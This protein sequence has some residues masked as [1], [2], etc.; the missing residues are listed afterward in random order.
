M[1][2]ALTDAYM[3][4]C[5]KRIVDGVEN[6][7]IK[8]IQSQKIYIKE[9][10]G[11]LRYSMKNIT[12]RDDDIKHIVIAGSQRDFLLYI[13]EVGIS[14]SSALFA[15]DKRVVSSMALSNFKIHITVDAK[16]SKNNAIDYIKNVL[17]GSSG[18]LNLDI[19][20]QHTT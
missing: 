8:D 1:N 20:Q 7:T 11:K 19:V 13:E 15:V 6:G 18:V 4:D 10:E 2:K 17:A 3:E 12:E 16:K 14:R 9:K 5:I